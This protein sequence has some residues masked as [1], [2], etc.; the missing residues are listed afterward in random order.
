[1]VPILVESTASYA[2]KSMIC[3]GLGITFQSDGFAVAYFKPLGRLPVRVGRETVDEDAVL[4]KEVFQLDAPL[5]KICPVV[6][7]QDLI[8]NAYDGRV[9][10]LDKKVVSAYRTVSRGK[11]ITL[12]GGGGSLH[13][14]S[15]LGLSSLRIAR[16][17]DAQVILVDN[18][19]QEVNVDCVIRSQEGLGPNLIGVILN[20]IPPQRMDFIERKIIPFL[21]RKGITV[22]GTIP[23]DPL[24]GSVSV[25]ELKQVLNGQFLSGEKYGADLIEKFFVGSMNVDKAIEYF[26]KA[27]H[28]AV[29]VGGDRPDV[30]LAALE[31][32]A[33][34]VVLTGGYYPNDI[35]IARA[36]EMKVPLILVKEDTYTTVERVD[37]VLGRMRVKEKRKIEV[38]TRIIKKCINFKLLYQQI[39]L[40]KSR[41][42]KRS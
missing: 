16:D 20:R 26:K 3:L 19:E 8:I 6:V 37:R 7:T 22:L 11:D 23:F 27:R 1:M 14:G 42:R 13:E 29:I 18:A 34:C 2:G 40:K 15:L 17:F 30:I 24:L 39:G 36:E 4:I 21:R 41:R 32:R 12:I 28:K 5:N 35:I 9:E 38:A 25:G 31:T 33:S 10:G